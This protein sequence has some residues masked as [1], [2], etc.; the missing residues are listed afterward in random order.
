MWQLYHRITGQ[1]VTSFFD[2][3]L[4]SSQKAAEIVKSVLIK[5]LLQIDRSKDLSERELVSMCSFY[6]GIEIKANAV[7]TDDFVN[8]RDNLI[9]WT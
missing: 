1:D 2:V 4:C 7:R 8:T 5:S 6:L 9:G 3:L